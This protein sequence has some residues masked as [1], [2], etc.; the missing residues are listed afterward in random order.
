MTNYTRGRDI[1][2][3]V[4]H[5]LEGQGYLAQRA[6][7]SKGNWDVYAVSQTGVLLV[8]CKRAKDLKSAR[9]TYA[10]EKKKLLTLA[11]KV[12][13]GARQGLY[14]WIDKAP[15][16]LGGG[17]YTQEI[18]NTNPEE[19][20]EESPIIQEVDEI[21]RAEVLEQEIHSLIEDFSEARDRGL[22]AVKELYD[23]I[24][25]HAVHMDTENL[26]KR[27][28]AAAEVMEDLLLAVMQRKSL[29]AELRKAKANAKTI[30]EARKLL[31][32][33][34]FDGIEVEPEF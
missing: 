21:K 26:T 19:Q 4:T 15:G 32:D 3:K 5:L 30:Q 1:E 8:S 34:E 13:N 16:S 11:S 28:E 2:Y 18:I 22:M 31:E 7:S 9:S 14:I 33:Q 10:A 6:A 23:S 25:T 24:N 17:W 29:T 20:V 12:P 27:I